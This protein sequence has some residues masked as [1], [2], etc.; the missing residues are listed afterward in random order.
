METAIKGR[1]SEQQLCKITAPVCSKVQ[2]K[3]FKQSRKTSCV[4]VKI[5]L[6]L[7]FGLIPC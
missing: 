1:D 4:I 5:E 7:D 6:R 2:P 3:F